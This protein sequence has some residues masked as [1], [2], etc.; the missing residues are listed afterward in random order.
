[1]IQNL[2]MWQQQGRGPFAL[3]C[4]RARPPACRQGAMLSSP[5]ALGY[6]T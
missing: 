6:F 2:L 5:P 1:M 4:V 3:P